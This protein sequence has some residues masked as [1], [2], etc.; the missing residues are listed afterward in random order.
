MAATMQ[1]VILGTAAYMSPE[2][3]KGRLVDKRTDIFAF[4]CVLFEMLTGQKAFEGKTHASLLG[5]IM[6]A[7]PPPVSQVQP[8][9]P[10]AV[11]RIVERCVAK[12]PDDRWQTARDL[13]HELKW[14]AEGGV[15]RDGVARPRCRRCARPGHAR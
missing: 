9:A 12:D 13:V 7:T 3:A 8:V 4:G 11:N 1:G 5:A 2:Q 10:A 14:V 6:H 15:S